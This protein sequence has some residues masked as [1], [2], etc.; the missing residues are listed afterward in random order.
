QARGEA[1][2]RRADIFS[3]GIVLWEALSVKRLFKGD[4]EAATLN[5]VLHE[6]IVPPSTYRSGIP[7]ALEAVCMKALERDAVDRWAT[8]LELADELERVARSLSCASSVRDV[9]ACLETVF[10]PDLSQQRE[11]VR[12]WLAR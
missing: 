12:A 4:G 8:A 7:P 11:A 2:D 5:K 9:A 6:P 3:C 1:I 10:G